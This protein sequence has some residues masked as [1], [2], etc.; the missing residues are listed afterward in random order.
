M[1]WFIDRLL[2]VCVGGGV[3]IIAHGC[4]RMVIDVRGGRAGFWSLCSFPPVFIR[5]TWR[6]T[7]GYR[8]TV[9]TYFFVAPGVLCRTVNVFC[10]VMS[11]SAAAKKKL[12]AGE[13][14]SL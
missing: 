9:K 2:W 12:H 13:P 3:I 1:E 8:A 5:S 7:A 11:C 10:P 6:V 14:S 4:S